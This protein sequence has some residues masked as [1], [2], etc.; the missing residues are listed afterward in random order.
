MGNAAV[1]CSG[2]ICRG[3][4]EVERSGSTESLVA[5]P[6]CVASAGISDA[7]TFLDNNWNGSV[8]GFVLLEDWDDSV[9][10]FVLFRDCHV[11]VEEFPSWNGWGSELTLFGN[12]NCGP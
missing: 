6:P 11:D 2:D 4:R 5:L 12:W 3:E 9:D 7:E 8:D 10:E 1:L